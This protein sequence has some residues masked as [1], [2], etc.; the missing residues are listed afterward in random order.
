[1]TPA[2][3]HWVMSYVACALVL[4]AGLTGLARLGLRRAPGG[5]WTL[6]LGL[7]AVAI[8]VLPMGGFTPARWLA[9]L[10]V[11][12]S[13]PFLALLLDA[14]VA[15]GRGRGWLAPT[16]RTLAWAWG[17]VAGL[18]LYPSALGLGRFDAYGLGWGFSGLGL[19]VLALTAWLVARGQ[20]LGVVLVLSAAAWQAGLFE[21]ANYWDY[22]VDPVFAAVSL[23]AFTRC[24][25][26]RPRQV[27][28]GLASPCARASQ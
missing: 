2:L 14:G 13:V 19:A 23:V 10:G 20:R 18:A 28:A 21:S 25:V 24:A 11:V 3:V 26:R 6:G 27:Q 1:M 7:L 9:G 22:L 4:W 15:N 16:D 8:S 5:R 17:A 12:P